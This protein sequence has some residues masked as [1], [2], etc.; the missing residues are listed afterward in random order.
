MTQPVADEAA[1]PPVG[2]GAEVDAARP[3]TTP[4][5]RPVLARAGLFLLL[6]VVCAPV[7]ALHVDRHR[8][9]SVLDEFAYADYLYKVHGGQLYVRHGEVSGQPA[10]RALACRGYEPA[11]WAAAD[12][13]PCDSPSFLPEV[14]P[15][16]GVNSA[17][18]HPPTY[19]LVTDVGARVVLALG[20]TDD[21]ITA[22]RLVGAVWMAA[23]LLALW[24]L[25][26]AVEVNR[27]AAS[28]GLVL[29]GALPFLLR[30]WHFLTPDAANVLVGSLVGLAVLHWERTGWSPAVL[31]AA[32]AA[33][34]A[35]KAPNMMVVLAAAGYLVGRGVVARRAD[36]VTGPGP[37]RLRRLPSYL[38]AGASLLAGALATSA[39]W[40]AVRAAL[41]VPGGVSPL[42]A[43]ERLATFT[44]AHLSRNLARFFNVWDAEGSGTYPL[45][46]LASYLLIGSLLVAL[47]TLDQ[48][49]RRR[50]LALAVGAVMVVGPLLVVVL[51]AALRGAYAPVEPRYGATL[52]PLQC[53]IAASFWRTRWSLVPVGA[54]AVALSVAVLAVS[55]DG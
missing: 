36:H 12:R 17:D 46:L 33:A 28:F 21:L 9:L 19:F 20:L 40:L 24:C 14:F 7:V 32:G 10:L 41:A 55:L 54:L 51:N 31:A 27:W 26:R 4:P 43:D 37:A 53:A 16:A 34:M 6:L 3:A 42:D 2:A 49:D 25:L 5:T 39:A 44:P 29:V 8:A 47:V 45:A 30:S 15:N 38:R 23:G 52:V 1:P 50:S 35:V 48:R 11:T 22:G 18:I 13:P